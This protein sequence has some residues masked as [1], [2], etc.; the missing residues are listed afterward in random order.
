MLR[1]SKSPLQHERRTVGE[2]LHR[3]AP[4]P[5]AMGRP[6]LDMEVASL[7]PTMTRVTLETVAVV[8]QLCVSSRSLRSATCLA[9][10]MVNLTRIYTRT[11]DGGETK[12]GDM[13]TT[14]KNDLRLQAYADVDEANANLGVALAQ[15][16]A[17]GR[18]GGGAD[19][20]PER[21]VRRRRRL[22]HAGRRRPGVPAAADRAGLRRP[23][24]GVVRPLQRGPAEAALVH[25]QRRHP[26]RRPPPRRAHRR[27]PGRA[28]GLGGVRASTARP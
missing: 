16:R 27:T 18:R 23:A 2:D 14:T 10:P 17:R 22:L 1:T 21:P 26:R 15:R 4:F 24:R 3:L 20:R 6:G 19:P 5:G 13:S 12:L 8:G 9:W 28:V 11:G 7:V 25:P